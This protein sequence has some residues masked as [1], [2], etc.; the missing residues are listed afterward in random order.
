ME[1]LLEGRIVAVDVTL[2]G[3]GIPPLQKF[4]QYEE[5]ASASGVWTFSKQM[6]YNSILPGTGAPTAPDLIDGLLP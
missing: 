5:F 4:E 2:P 6:S 3:T 1:A